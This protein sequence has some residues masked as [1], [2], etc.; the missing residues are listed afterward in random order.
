[1]PNSKERPPRKTTNNNSIAPATG[2]MFLLLIKFE[3][4]DY[5]YPNIGFD[6]FF[7]WLLTCVLCFCI[8]LIAFFLSYRIT[9]GLRI[10]MWLAAGVLNTIIAFWLYA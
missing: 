2:L 5:L 1:M 6:G 7:S 8:I 9:S 3:I 10:Y 4:L